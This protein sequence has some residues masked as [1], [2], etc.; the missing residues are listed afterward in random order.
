MF[1]IVWTCMQ[2]WVNSR[3]GKVFFCFF[4]LPQW[5]EENYSESPGSSAARLLLIFPF[6]TVDCCLKDSFL[7][8]Y[9]NN[10]GFLIRQC[11]CSFNFRRGPRGKVCRMCWWTSCFL[12]FLRYFCKL[13]THPSAG[14]LVIA[15]VRLHLTP[16][17]AGELDLQV[18]LIADTFFQL[19]QRQK[20]ILMH[21]TILKKKATRS[22]VGGLQ[23]MNLVKKKLLICQ[24]YSQILNLQRKCLTI[25]SSGNVFNN[26]LIS[27]PLKCFSCSFFPKQHEGCASKS[28]NPRCQIPS[29]QQQQKKEQTKKT[30]NKTVVTS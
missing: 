29:Q 11:T 16:Q 20:P 27:I 18:K 1:G 28:L 5:R 6:Y 17:V 24:N 7:G 15:H 9:S 13:H 22:S 14:L 3:M 10:Y 21:R 26:H 23:Q 19:G 8:T 25:E 12:I 2:N 30:Q 4:L